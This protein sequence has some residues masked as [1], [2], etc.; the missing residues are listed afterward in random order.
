VALPAE[1]LKCVSIVCGVGPPDIGMGGADLMHWLGFTLGYPYGP[2]F[3]LRWFWQRELLGRIDLNDEQRLEMLFQQAKGIIN[4]KDLDIYK[5]TG[6]L[7]VVLRS[8]R[9]SFVHG[10]DAAIQDGRLMALPF[11]FKVEDIRHDLDVQL[12]YGKQDVFVP[13]NHGEQIAVRLGGRAYLR[14]EDE[15]HS[16]LQIKDMDEILEKLVQSL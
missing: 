5:D 8:S 7:R 3:M 1:Q 4:P 11:G 16:S 6:F 9:E 2:S 14:V 12:W 13:A 10:Y 15:T